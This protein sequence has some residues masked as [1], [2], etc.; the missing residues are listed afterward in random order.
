LLLD[1][2][3]RMRAPRRGVLGEHVPA[4]AMAAVR[5][6]SAF[7]RLIEPDEIAEALLWAAT[8][9]VINGSVIHANLGQVER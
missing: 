9:P 6:M 4:D 5:A 3:L 1:S 7:N 8:R 2:L